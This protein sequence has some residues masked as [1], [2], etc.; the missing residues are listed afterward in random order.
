MVHLVNIR[1]AVQPIRRT[2]SEGCVGTDDGPVGIGDED[3]V[4]SEIYA[5][6]R[7]N[8]VIDPRGRRNVGSRQI[9]IGR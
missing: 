4:G 3:I 7:R 9:A 6:H 2:D 1:N 8:A 5:R